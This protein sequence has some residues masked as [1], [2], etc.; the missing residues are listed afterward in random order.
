MQE[1]AALAS[2]VAA[3]SVGVISPG[4]SFVM[5]AR[6]AVASSRIR[7]LATAL[8]M[9]AGGAIFGAVALLGLQSI[10]LAVPVLYTGLRVLGGLYLCYLGFLIF[11]SAR[12]PVTTVAAGG[13]ASSR[14]FRAFWLGVTTQVSNPK[15]AIVYASVFAAFLPASF[16]LGFAAALLAAVFFVESAWYA[17]VAVLFS[18][19]GPQRAYLSYKSWVDRAAGAVMFGLGLKLMTSAAK[20]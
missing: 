14:P 10:L 18:S 12:Q 3:L 13:E 6:V 2:I 16:S 11:R 15:T 20:P 7:A 8:G 1:L 4:P 17:L 5:V 19:S 9:G